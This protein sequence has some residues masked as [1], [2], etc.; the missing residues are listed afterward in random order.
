MDLIIVES[1]HKAKTISK[2]LGKQYMV[3]ASGGHI[4]DLP[5][6]RMGIDIEHDF[7]PEYVITESKKQTIENLRKA[8]AKADKVYL[9]TDP[10]REGEAIAWHLSIALEIPEE[11]IRRV[12]FNEIGRAHV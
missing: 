2:Y 10:D 6:H 8:I 1:P 5:E 4:S 11:K 9:A 7:K 12:T 3:M